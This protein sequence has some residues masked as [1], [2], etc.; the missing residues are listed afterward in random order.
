MNLNKVILAGNL[1]NDPEIRAMPNGDPVATLSLATNEYWTNSNGE[2]VQHTEW[3][4]IVFFGR[5][6]EICRQYLRKGAQVYIEGRLRTR[7]W[8]DQYGQERY[9]IEI[10]GENLQFVGGQGGQNSEEQE[11]AKA[12]PV[13]N[14]QAKPAQEQEQQ[15]QPQDSQSQ[16]NY[17]DVPF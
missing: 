13:S 4:R 2:K 17:D 5:H 15:A 9:T 3:H 12:K 7:K 8:Q 11:Q 1:G 14:Q 10:R 6:A 16:D